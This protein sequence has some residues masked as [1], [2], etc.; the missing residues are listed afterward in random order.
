MTMCGVPGRP[1]ITIP[2]YVLASR[3]RT[4]SCLALRVSHHR[5]GR[6]RRPRSCS[7]ASGPHRPDGNQTPAAG[8]P[9]A[10]NWRERD[11]QT[12]GC[13]NDCIV[14]L[15]DAVR[16]VAW[17]PALVRGSMASE[18]SS[19]RKALS[20]GSAQHPDPRST[21]PRKLLRGSLPSERCRRGSRRL[22]SVMI[23]STNY[24]VADARANRACMD[25]SRC[26]ITRGNTPLLRPARR[27]S[28][29]EGTRDPRTVERERIEGGARRYRANRRELNRA[30]KRAR[31]CLTTCFSR[32][33][34]SRVLERDNRGA[35]R[36]LAPYAA[37]RA[38]SMRRP[39]LRSTPR[40]SLISRI[41]RTRRPVPQGLPPAGNRVERT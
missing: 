12:V 13:G 28:S 21:C 26:I 22:R 16:G 34:E 1:A 10:T 20:A 15:P 33:L 4:T 39:I 29:R 32:G 9:S 6:R 37:H 5:A 17:W 31:K 2:V 38:R 3:A 36:R 7:A 35:A 27:Q 24:H 25:R 41:S 19:Q 30:A 11:P 23:V 18:V 14:A 8:P 40:R